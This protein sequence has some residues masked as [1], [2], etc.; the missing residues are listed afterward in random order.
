M[1]KP[2]KIRRSVAMTAAALVLASGATVATT[3]TAHADD[4]HC[5]LFQGGTAGSPWYGWA[6]SPCIEQDPHGGGYLAYMQ[7]HGGTTDVRAYVGI[8]DSCNGVTYGING[9]SDANHWLP[10]GGYPDPWVW[11]SHKDISCSSGVWAIGRIF[12]SGNGSPWAW[13]ERD[14]V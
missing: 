4:F 12:E 9:D 6:L 3:G 1:L 8:Y 7:G 5:G 14:P 2:F 10:G 13:S 11:S